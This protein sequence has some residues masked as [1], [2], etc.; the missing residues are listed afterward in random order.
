M[1]SHFWHKAAL[2]CS[3]LLTTENGAEK[4]IHSIGH[5]ATLTFLDLQYFSLTEGPT[6]LWMWYNGRGK[7][8]GFLTQQV[9][10]PILGLSWRCE[11]GCPTS[12]FSCIVELYG[13]REKPSN[14]TVSHIVLLG[15]KTI[16]SVRL[17]NHNY[18]CF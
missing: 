3:I 10:C 6:V 7:G 16:K 4:N 9:L 1:E 15:I 14:I 8:Y 18:Y 2:Y 17:F 11:E 12:K 5:T 13:Y